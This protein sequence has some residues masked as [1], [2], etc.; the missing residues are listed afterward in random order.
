MIA[1]EIRTRAGAR[2]SIVARQ[3]A[4]AGGFLRPTAV[5]IVVAGSKALVALPRTIAPTRT[6]ATLITLGKAAPAIVIPRS[7]SGGTGS[8]P[9]AAEAS[10]RRA[11]AALVAPAEIPRA[12]PTAFGSPR[13]LA[14]LLK[15]RTFAIAVAMAIAA[16]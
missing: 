10:A 15:R 16:A 8:A 12:A 13:A 2:S 14:T 1:K 5:S 6:P 9:L 7:L 4:F 3:F 11:E